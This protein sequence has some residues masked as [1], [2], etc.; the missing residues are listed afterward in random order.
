MQDERRKSEII[1]P[2]NLL[3]DFNL[4]QVV[5]VDLHKTFHTEGMDLRRKR[6]D[7]AKSFG[8]H[9]TTRSGLLDCIAHCIESDRPYADRLKSMEDCAQIGL[10]LPMFHVDVDLSWSKRSP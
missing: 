5:T 7:E 3:C 9:E 10:P 4:L 6:F 1:D 8:Y 2:V